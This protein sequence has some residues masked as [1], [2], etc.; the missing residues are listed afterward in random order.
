MT[1]T[2]IEIKIDGTPTDGK[3][4]WLDSLVWGTRW[5]N[6]DG[7][8]NTTQITYFAQA[9]EDPHNEFK[10]T[11]AVWNEYD[12]VALQHAFTAWSNVANIQFVAGEENNSDIWLWKTTSKVMPGWLGWSDV[13]ASQYSSG[14]PLYVV[15]NGDHESASPEGMQ[16]GGYG[17]ITLIHELG[18]LIGLAH[19]HDG[20]AETDG[21]VFPQVNGPFDSYGQFDLNQGIW[22]TMSYNDG[23]PVHFPDHQPN[24]FIE[25]GWQGTP[26]ALDI[27]AIQTIYGKNNSYKLGDDTYQLPDLNAAGTYWS[28]IW[29]SGGIDTISNA[30]SSQACNIDLNAAKLTGANAGG[31]VSHNLHTLGGFTIANGVT[32]ENAIG[33]SGR[34]HIVGN[35]LSNKIDGMAGSDYMAG[36]KGNDF[37]WVRDKG[38]EVVEL[39]KGGIDTVYSYLQSYSLTANVEN[40]EIHFSGA[41][42][43]IGNKLANTIKGG[44]G[45]DILLGKGGDDTLFGD[46]GNDTLVGGAGKDTLTGGEGN[47]TFT[48][49]TWKDSSGQI[50]ERDIITDFKV[51]LDLIDLSAFD[52]NIL[53]RGVQSF[54]ELKMGTTPYVGQ[55]ATPG[56]LYFDQTEQVLYANVDADADA[57][58]SVQITGAAS[59]SMADLV[60]QATV[61]I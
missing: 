1:G 26:M 51:G 17:Y 54:T 39:S 56:E 23:W 45:D 9:G 36:G 49:K 20:G 34:D 44:A 18:H 57:D 43:L 29:D 59:L 14:E 61:L 13:P 4:P 7:S 52:A 5:M 19:P 6:S 30:G 40:A 25:Y 55:F 3:N 38:D 2:A 46:V 12:L 15:V 33:G 27:A 50:L 28:C 48:F 42:Q 22:T 10:A 32:I 35:K 41:A 53:Q 11:G 60:L 47:N 24:R 58:F 8:D 31:F 37:Y 16:L 21:N